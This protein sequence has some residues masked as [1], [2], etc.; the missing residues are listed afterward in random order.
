MWS[1]R[2]RCVRR[3]DRLLCGVSNWSTTGPVVTVLAPSACVVD[4]RCS[5][6]G[7][8]AVAVLFVGGVDIVHVPP[9][10]FTDTVAP[11][12]GQPAV[13]ADGHQPRCPTDGP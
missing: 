10:W 11:A 4:G 6:I 8:T 7:L 1:R 12:G 13:V 3:T 5:A 2:N 9:Y